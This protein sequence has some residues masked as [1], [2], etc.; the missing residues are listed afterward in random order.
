MADGSGVSG[1]ASAS[2]VR[3]FLADYY[4]MSE[5]WSVKTSAQRVI[6]AA[7]SWLHAETR[8]SQHAH[9]R[10]EGYVCTLSMLVLKSGVAHTFH[11]GNSRICR[12]AGRSLEQIT[13]DHRVAV[14]SQQSHLGRALGINPHVEI[15]YHA[16]RIEPGDIFVL[17]TD[18]V[19][20]HLRAEAITGE[21]ATSPDDL[22]GT[23]RRIVEKAHAAGSP[24]NL[25]IQI[26]RIDTLALGDLGGLIDPVGELLP[27]PP[28]DAGMVFD[29]YKVLRTIHGSSQSHVCLASDIETGAVVVLKT[30]SIDG[31]N[32]PAYLK[33]FMMEEWIA[34]RLNSPHVLKAHPR[35]RPGPRTALRAGWSGL[36]NGRREKSPAGVSTAPAVRPS[37]LACLLPEEGMHEAG[38]VAAEPVAHL[39]LFL[40]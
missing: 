19:H 9:D 37:P 18:G 1:V 2:A 4:C 30:P 24:D 40:H 38:Q 25:T 7:N 10:D 15:D 33:R 23:A 17:T 28:L 14:S 22:D 32:D 6:A 29:G 5:A 27:V 20:D 16:V 11:V 26:V 21:I 36:L 34:R 31:R 39:L 8:R 3:S 35:T 13:G 12:V